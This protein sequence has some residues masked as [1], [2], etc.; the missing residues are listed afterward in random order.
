MA[1]QKSLIAFTLPQIEKFWMKIE[2][3]YWVK[4]KLDYL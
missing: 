2:W 4:L 3:L 1:A